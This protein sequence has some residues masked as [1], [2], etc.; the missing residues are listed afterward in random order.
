MFKNYK[1]LEDS[2]STLLLLGLAHAQSEKQKLRLQ[3]E[4]ERL[5]LETELV[6]PN[7]KEQVLFSITEPAPQSFAPNPVSLKSR[8]CERKV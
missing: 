8:E 3:Q 4:Q 1:A 6:K 2:F 5:T 7:P